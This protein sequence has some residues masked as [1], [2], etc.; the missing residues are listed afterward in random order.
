M[1]FLFKMT[2]LLRMIIILVIIIIIILILFKNS[3]IKSFN[4]NYGVFCPNC[5]KNNWMGESECNS[6]INCGWCINSNGDGSCGLGTPAGPMFKDCRTWYHGGICRWGPDCGSIGPIYVKR[7]PIN[8][9]WMPTWIN[10]RWDY[11]DWRFPS[12]NWSRWNPFRRNI[13]RN[14]RLSRQNRRNNWFSGWKAGWKAGSKGKKGGKN[15]KG[16]K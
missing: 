16:K 2:P 3:V 8:L 9:H 1:K 10:T 12:W 6:C 7:P 14:R 4:E 15:K 5:R 11:S 13:R